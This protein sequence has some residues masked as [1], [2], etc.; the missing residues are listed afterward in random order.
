MVPFFMIIL[1]PL[2]FIILDDGLYKLIFGLQILFYSAAFVGAL[3]RNQKYAILKPITKTCYVPYVFCL[4]NFAALIG[5]YRFI[6]AKQDV[7]WQKAR[8]Q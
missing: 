7:T 8:K 6:S 1:F 4:L 3:S 5:F 2:N